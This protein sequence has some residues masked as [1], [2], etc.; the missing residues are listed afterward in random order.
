MKRFVPRLI[1]FG[2]LFVVAAINLLTSF[3]V[4]LL[5]IE[6]F[7]LALIALGVFAG[8]NHS[9]AKDF[10]LL[11][12]GWVLF[13]VLI[14]ENSL[15]IEM[16]VVGVRRFFR[17]IDDPFD[18]V[19]LLVGAV[20]F[21]ILQLFFRQKKALAVIYLR[22]ISMFIFLTGLQVMMLGGGRTCFRYVIFIVLMS[23][24]YE[25]KTRQNGAHQRRTISCLLSFLAYALAFLVFDYG[26]GM[27]W[28]DYNNMDAVW[29]R[30]IL[31]VAV[32]GGLMILEEYN[33]RENLKMPPSAFRDFGW[34][35]VFWSLLCLIMF[36][37]PVFANWFA[38]VVLPIILYYCYGF[39]IRRWLVVTRGKE[40]KA[41]L[42]T[43]SLAVV[44]LLLFGKY[45]NAY[46]FISVLLIL[47]LIVVA[48]C[49]SVTAKK[50]NHDLIMVCYYGIAAIIMLFVA[51]VIT[52][53][54]QPILL[55]KQLL[56][57]VFFSVVWCAL[58]ITTHGM[59][60]NASVIYPIEFVK[61]LKFE[62]YIPLV[63]LVPT[64][65]VLLIR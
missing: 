61:I 52:D 48:I 46:S 47:L 57:M 62:K 41:M 32:M 22:Y 26:D 11:A 2:V 23:L 29:L 31:G 40:R 37:C 49:W 43:W 42:V 36:V 7:I 10:P 30:I 56:A 33:N 63:M 50:S 55:A 17:S 60:K 13:A 15:S 16:I 35:M 12:M 25:L 64:I 39:F 3:S 58:C 5:I 4:D 18:N 8:E 9:L 59:N 20:S 38:L 19:V 14:L 51:F 1:A 24:L 34:V 54:S 21:A 53:Y 45:L 28:F 27:R 65:L 6:C 44:F